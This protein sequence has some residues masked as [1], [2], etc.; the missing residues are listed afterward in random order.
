MM[1]RQEV[2]KEQ[3]VRFIRMYEAL[4]GLSVVTYCVMGHHFHI[5]VEVPKRPEVLPTDAG[6]VALIRREF[7]GH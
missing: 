2:E 3:F 5:L 7:V 4:F 1:D 6:L